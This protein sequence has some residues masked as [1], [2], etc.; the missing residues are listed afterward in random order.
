MTITI[1]NVLGREV[2]DSRGNP[3]VEAEVHLSDGSIGRAIVPSGASTGKHEAVELRDG[4][5]G[6]FGG[7]GVLKAVANIAEK[8]APALKGKSPFDQQKIDSLLV[9]LDGSADKSDLGA[10]AILGVSMAVA[11]AA[12]ASKGVPLYRYL[13]S[14]DTTLPVPMFNILNGGQ[15]ASNSTDFQEFMVVPVGSSSFAEALRAGA[16]IYR[17]LGNI[18]KDRNLTT[19]VGDEGGYAP[20]LLSNKDALEIVLLAVKRAGYKAGD[21]CFIALDVAASEF[22]QGGVYKLEREGAALTSSELVDF[23][24]EWLQEYPIISIED[25]LAEDDWKGWKGL[26]SR[27]GDRVQ[28][29]G[30]DLYATNTERIEKGVQMKAS[31]AV[32]IKPNQIGTLTETLEAVSMTKAAGWAT[33][34]SHRSGE[35]E[36]S[37]I[38]DLAVAWDTRQ[39]K[40]GATA[41]SERLAK[42]N[43]LLRIEAELGSK[44]RYAGREAYPRLAKL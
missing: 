9:D 36:D 1:K 33:V 4:D 14:G 40:T 2:L 29:V 22:Y 18:L 23:Y 26:A 15:H 19:T 28:L 43:R 27:L 38:A 30:D 7:K 31:N 39:I 37:T 5:H 34:M 42:Y 8:I 35:T 41:R 44:A 24:L 17:A 12:A 25:G 20:P 32:L 3:T 13:N 10:N 16:E 11:H 6:R 21:E